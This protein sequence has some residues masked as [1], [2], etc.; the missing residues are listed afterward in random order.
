M[1]DYLNPHKIYTDEISRRIDIAPGFDSVRPAVKESLTTAL[2]ENGLV[3][4]GCG[5]KARIEES[6]FAD[7]VDNVGLKIYMVGCAECTIGFEGYFTS[8]EDAQEHWNTAM[9]WRE[10]E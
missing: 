1:T 6:P 7:D 9:G 5:G 2:D 10:K 4:C 8:I 3:P